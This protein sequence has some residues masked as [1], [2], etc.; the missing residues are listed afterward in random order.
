MEEILKI[1]KEIKALE[2]SKGVRFSK[3]TRS[4]L[5][6]QLNEL[7]LPLMEN[8][9]YLAVGDYI[10]EKWFDPPSGRT[11]VMIYTRE[12]WNKKENYSGDK[13]KWI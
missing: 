1:I 9:M 12:S 3:L 11:R 13:L 5:R 6:N 7:V 4:G 10:L 8:Q 2:G